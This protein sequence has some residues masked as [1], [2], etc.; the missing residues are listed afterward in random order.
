M[1][2]IPVGWMPEKMTLGRGCW[3]ALLSGIDAGAD[4]D[5]NS[6]LCGVDL[7]TSRLAA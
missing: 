1:W 7:K 6:L 2:G 4:G 5:E 3:L